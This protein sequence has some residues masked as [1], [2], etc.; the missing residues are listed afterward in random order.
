MSRNRYSERGEKKERYP[1]SECDFHYARLI[2]AFS[3]F[4]LLIKRSG[5]YA[6]GGAGERS[7]RII[8]LSISLREISGLQAF[9]DFMPS[10]KISTNVSIN[11]FWFVLFFFFSPNSSCTI[12]WF[13]IIPMNAFDE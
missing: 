6:A 13:T 9:P 3:G 5:K 12:I 1:V 4:G 10:R 7:Y 2:R 11:S 8:S